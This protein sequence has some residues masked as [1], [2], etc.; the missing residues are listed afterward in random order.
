MTS[1]LFLLLLIASATISKSRW[2]LIELEDKHDHG[3]AE[4]DGNEKDLRV[5]GER[6]AKDKN[7]EKKNHKKDHG[8]NYGKNNGKDHGKDHGK[9]HGNHGKKDGKAGA[10]DDYAV[11]GGGLN[12]FRSPFMQW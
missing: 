7:H 8:T 6:L 4:K 9:N 12:R 3:E 10:G 11:F 1:K 2:S 5:E